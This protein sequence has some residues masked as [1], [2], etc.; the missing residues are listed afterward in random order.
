[1]TFLRVRRVD[2]QKLSTEQL[3][4]LALAAA[5]LDASRA[6]AHLAP[7][8]LRR[9]ELHG[10][11]NLLT[12]C[13]STVAEAPS[14]EAAASFLELA[15]QRISPDQIPSGIWDVLEFQAALDFIQSDRVSG[16][17][18][19]AAQAADANEDVARMFLQTL[20]S[21]GLVSPDGRVRGGAFADE[22]QGARTIE[23]DRPREEP[24]I[25]TPQSESRASS[26]GKIWTPS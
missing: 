17:F 24:K 13:Q 22:E 12:V 3:A 20:I 9:P 23:R 18:N 5:I 6:T 1:M 7:E 11:V 26:P 15:R 21:H 25:W 8:I 4:K 10:L 16:L 14:F 2:A 19:R